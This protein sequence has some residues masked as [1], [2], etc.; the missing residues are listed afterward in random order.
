MFIRYLV[1]GIIIVEVILLIEAYNLY[2]KIHTID[3]AYSLE[4]NPSETGIE[5]VSKLHED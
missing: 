2:Y 5:R 3:L 1:T 4:T